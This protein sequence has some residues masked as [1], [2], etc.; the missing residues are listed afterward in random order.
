MA[1]KKKDYYENNVVSQLIAEREKRLKD[2]QKRVKEYLEK[3]DY[4]NLEKE[5]KL[6]FLLTINGIAL[7]EGMAREDLTTVEI[8]T[9]LALSQK[10]LHQYSREN[11]DIYDAIDR[12]RAE[13]VNLVETALFEMARDR[14]V[15]EERVQENWNDRTPENKSYYKQVFKRV[16]PANFQAAQ[17]ILNTHKNMEYRRQLEDNNNL[18][19]ERITF[20]IE[21]PEIDLPKKEKVEDGE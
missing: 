15:E 14:V 9:T 17:Y 1:Y 10:D 19:K 4:F 11:P 21:M 3:K 8:A 20:V 16:I 7:I 18:D 2:I 6:E 12:G 13:K 5:K